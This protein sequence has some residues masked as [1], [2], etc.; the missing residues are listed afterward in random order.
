MISVHLFVS[1]AP[2]VIEEKTQTHVLPSAMFYYIYTQTTIFSIVKKLNLNFSRNVGA[3][4]LQ[5]LKE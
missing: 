5:F 2:E 4:D 3:I 1:D